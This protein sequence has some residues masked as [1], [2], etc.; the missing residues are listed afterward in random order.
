M[1]NYHFMGYASQV[2]DQFGVSEIFV[3]RVITCET[4]QS[5]G[6]RSLSDWQIVDSLNAQH[7]KIY[8]YTM[9]IEYIHHS[10]FDTENYNEN[11]NLYIHHK[12]RIEW[13]MS[14]QRIQS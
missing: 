1:K 6:H 14:N 11:N 9:I 13:T 5:T 8:V 4:V 10:L 7:S 2:P 3:C 12:S